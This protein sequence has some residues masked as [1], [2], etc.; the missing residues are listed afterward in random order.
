M[1]LSDNYTSHMSHD[2]V[3]ERLSSTKI[4]VIGAEY[5]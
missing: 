3:F 2:D 1:K 4:D 5:L